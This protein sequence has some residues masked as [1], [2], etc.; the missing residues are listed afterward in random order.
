M[1]AAIRERALLQHLNLAHPRAHAAAAG[2]SAQAAAAGP[3][4]SRPHSSWGMAAAAAAAPCAATEV[5]FLHQE[6]AINV[7]VDLMSEPGFSIDQLMELAGLSCACAA[8]EL[9]PPQSKILLVCG[10]GNNGGDGLVAARHLWH[11]GYRPSVVYPKR[12]AKQLFRNLVAQSEQL[13]IP[14]LSELPGGGGGGDGSA[15]AA[16]GLQEFGLVVDAI[17]G[18]SFKGQPRAPFDSI[19]AALRASPAPVLSVDIPSGWD[20]EA[21]PQGGDS[22]MP[23]AL[24][25]LT[26]RARNAPLA[27]PPPPPPPFS[28]CHS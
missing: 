11:F 19:L 26:V 24:I 12:P 20:V 16:A 14:V 3:A 18:F 17:F 23:Q 27:A 28:F 4:A 2:K 9:A 5:T 8:A 1:R 21:G 7:D 10:P 13:G 6:Q 22:F 25:S 15:A